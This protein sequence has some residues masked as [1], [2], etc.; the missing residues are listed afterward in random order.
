MIGNEGGTV[1]PNARAVQ[2]SF[3]VTA[4]LI[5]VTDGLDGSLFGVTLPWMLEHGALGITVANSGAIVSAQLFGMLVGAVVAGIISDRLGK[6]RIIVST[7][8]IYGC[9]TIAQAAAPDWQVL[10]L[11]RFVAGVGLGGVIPA[12]IALVSEYSRPDRRFTN[13]TITSVGTSVG[14]FV[15]PLL[16]L[17]VL[18]VADFRWM[19]IIGGFFPLAMIPVALRSMP[20]SMAYLSARGRLEDVSALASR[21]GLES[22]GLEARPEKTRIRDLFS[23]GLRWRTILII[24]AAVF[25]IGFLNAFPTWFPQYLVAGGVQFTNALVFSALF[26]G[27]M[28][29]GGL[30][31]GR[32]QDRGNPRIVC[33]LF[34]VVNALLLTAIGLLLAAPLPVIGALVFLF[35]ASTSAFLFNGLVANSYPA[36][37]RGSILALD[38]GA[39]RAGAVVAGTLGGSLLAANLSPQWNLISW[40]ALPLLGGLIV[41]ALPAYRRGS[42]STLDK[43][44]EEGVKVA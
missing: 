39:G 43:A 24:I 9:F 20:E 10:I 12:L 15:A 16:A 4:T 1:V 13:N 38:F 32:L 34:L 27:G 8:A 28:V 19:F 33:G 29:V 22:A 23:R 2:A 3:I 44:D 21:F 31:G 18:N 5:A 42:G 37:L 11:F 36:R 35:G 25:V 6:R 41:L 26:T 7:L 30:F 14:G 17:M 40:A